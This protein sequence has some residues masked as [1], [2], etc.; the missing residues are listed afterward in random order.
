MNP[1]P[2]SPPPIVEYAYFLEFSISLLYSAIDSSKP[3]RSTYSGYQERGT[4]GLNLV[5]YFFYFFQKTTADFYSIA[6]FPRV[7]GAI[8]GSLIAIKGP[9]NE[10]HLYVGHKGFHAI[11]VMAVCNAQLLLTN[12]E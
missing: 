1:L 3:C 9:D 6:G 5:S 4:W 10:E 12:V 2:C 7:I 11:N 8:D